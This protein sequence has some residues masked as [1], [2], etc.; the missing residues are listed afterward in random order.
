MEE[1]LGEK[2]KQLVERQE[3]E[4]KVLRDKMNR[5]AMGGRCDEHN[6]YCAGPMMDL[7]DVQKQEIYTVLVNPEILNEWNAIRIEDDYK[8]FAEEAKKE[9]ACAE[10][11]K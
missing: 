11:M 8:K 10:K 7:I 4:M 9:P 6:Q 2:G 5:D 1:M 3:K